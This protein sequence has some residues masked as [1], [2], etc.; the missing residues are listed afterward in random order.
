MGV[1]GTNV[2]SAE[3]AAEVDLR[4]PPGA[5]WF[6]FHVE[7]EL[8]AGAVKLP[9]ETGIQ[10]FPAQSPKN[11]LTKSQTKEI[12]GLYRPGQIV[13][14]AVFDLLHPPIA[15]L[16]FQVLEHSLIVLL[17]LYILRDRVAVGIH[18]GG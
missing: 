6:L 7:K 9:P 1:Q 12:I 13:D 15:Q 5:F 4:L 3:A 16:L 11:L 18:F 2:I 17:G 8:A 14:E 10:S